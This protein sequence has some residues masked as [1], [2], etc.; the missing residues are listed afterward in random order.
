MFVQREKLG[1][2]IRRPGKRVN[3]EETQDVINAIKMKHLLNVA[4]PRAPPLEIAPTQLDPAII[5][6]APVLPPLLR[7]R[8]DLERPRR[9]CATT[10]VEIEDATVRPHI[11]AVTSHAKGDVADQ[12]DLLL[13]AIG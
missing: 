11:R 4:N 12:I 6:D 9:R 2:A 1:V 7:E 3:A 10:P 5:R 13:R 8:V